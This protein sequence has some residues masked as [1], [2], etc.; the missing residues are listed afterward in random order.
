MCVL[1]TEGVSA[2]C[3][4]GCTSSPCANG[5]RCVDDREVPGHYSCDCSITGY[6][7]P[8]CSYRGKQMKYSFYNGETIC[9]G[10]KIV[11]VSEY[12]CFP[13]RCLVWWLMEDILSHWLFSE[14]GLFF[15]GYS[16][17]L[18]RLKNLELSNRLKR[19][20]EPPQAGYQLRLDLNFT[21]KTIQPSNLSTLAYI[22]DISG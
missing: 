19:G 9:K 12:A 13:Q 16:W 10:Q 2:G 20:T 1:L 3:V 8:Y 17:L 6:V 21:A 22:G 15:D 11:D 4:S 18:E 7:G 14:Y 5:G